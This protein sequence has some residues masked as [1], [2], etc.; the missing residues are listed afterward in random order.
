L[1]ECSKE[2]EKIID[3]WKKMNTVFNG[4]AEMD[5]FAEGHLKLCIIAAILTERNSEKEWQKI[6]DLIDRL[7]RITYW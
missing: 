4:K 1:E 3:L 2:A 5:K 7:E 6:K